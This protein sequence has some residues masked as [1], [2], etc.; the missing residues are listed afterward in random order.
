[1]RLFRL[2][3]GTEII[4]SKVSL[5][6][7]IKGICSD[8]R[9]MGDSIVFVAIRGTKR[10]GNNYVSDVLKNGCKCIITDDE[11]VF[12][13]YD[14]TILTYNSRRTLAVMWDNFYKNPTK[15][16][17]VIG[18]TGTNGKTSTAYFL[19][20]ILRAAGKSVGLISTVKCE[21]NGEVRNYGGGGEISDI[22]SAMTTPD[23]E[24][25]Y[26]I[27]NDMKLCGVEYVVMEASSHALELSKLYPIEFELGIF[28]NL[29]REHLD[30]HFNME[31]Y[32]FSKAK[33]FCK[34]RI[35]LING[36]DRQVRKINRYINRDFISFGLCRDNQY[37]A[38][39]ISVDLKGAS[40]RLV[41]K[42]KHIN[43][44]TS[45]PGEFSVYNSMAAACGADLLGIEERYI[46]E[47]CGRLEKIDGRME[48]IS[49][50]IY[51]DYAHSPGAFEEVIG[52]VRS[53]AGDKKLV[54]I[55]G[56]GG[57]RDRT[58]RPLMGKIATKMADVTIITSDN[59]RGEDKTSIIA[60]IEKG[61]CKNSI[62][63]VVL[64]RRDAIELGVKLRGDGILLILGKGHESYEIEKNEKRKFSE[65]DIVRN[66]LICNE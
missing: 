36:D 13:E 49:E 38:E 28:T 4:R 6:M 31:N 40:Y 24:I 22:V 23:P 56:C 37:R 20:E 54:V 1:M 10:N 64:D 30:F 19:Y 52:S 32:F 53:M 26:R 18:I 65:A 29:S 46:S 5:D 45:M 12:Y 8:S 25:L 55:F 59:P 14:N 2:M 33:L 41:Y 42:N 47:G 15:D 44:R 27:F 57:D 61:V 60:D 39:N 17:K 34:C 48:R 43:I 35:A 21:I 16:L 7:E 58:K 66:A 63:Y 3:E 11:A 62:F 51:I 9:K 50:G